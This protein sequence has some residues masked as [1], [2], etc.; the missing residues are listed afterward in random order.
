MNRP[1]SQLEAV[2][3]LSKRTGSRYSLQAMAKALALTS[4]DI[5]AA[6]AVLAEDDPRRALDVLRDYRE[7]RAAASADDAA[8]ALKTLSAYV[9]QEAK[10]VAETK[11]RKTTRRV[12]PRGGR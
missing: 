7:G 4:N 10:R 2:K 11:R 9:R 8:A 3:A 12:V 5:E 1:M 6:I